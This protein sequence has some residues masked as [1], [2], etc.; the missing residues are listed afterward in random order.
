[1]VN[2]VRESMDIDEMIFNKWEEAVLYQ[3]LQPLIKFLEKAAILG[4][5]ILYP[6]ERDNQKQNSH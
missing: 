1:M 3:R 4:N 2:L 6:F 5:A